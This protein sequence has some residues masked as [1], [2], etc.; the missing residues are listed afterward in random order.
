M[1]KFK[2]GESVRVK[3]LAWYNAH[4][5]SSGEIKIGPVFVEGM[6]K[7]CGKTLIISSMST[8]GM[9]EIKNSGFSWHVEFIEKIN[10]QLEFEFMK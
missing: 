5:D 6:A 10:R 7:Y 2:T 8:S 9:I 1:N 3:S 4:K